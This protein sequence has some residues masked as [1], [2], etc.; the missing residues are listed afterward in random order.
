MGDFILAET[1]AQ[2]HGLVNKVVPTTE[3]EQSTCMKDF[4][5]LP[6]SI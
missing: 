5:K 6:L 1:A 2:Q 3:L 4:S